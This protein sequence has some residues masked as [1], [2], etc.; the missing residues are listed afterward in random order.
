MR[1]Y[2]A[3][4]TRPSVA[5]LNSVAQ[6]LATRFE[7]SGMVVV[8]PGV[9]SIETTNDEVVACGQH[10]ATIATVRRV[11]NPVTSETEGALFMNL[12]LEHDGVPTEC[13]AYICILKDPNQSARS[14]RAL[15]TLTNAL[16]L[17]D[18]T[19]QLSVFSVDLNKHQELIAEGSVNPLAFEEEA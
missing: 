7:F 16:K 1:K 10:S 5:Y 2:T 4:L 13:S 12:V 9:N 11:F 6:G 15:I 18:L 8:D 14:S 3:L 19:L 17:Q